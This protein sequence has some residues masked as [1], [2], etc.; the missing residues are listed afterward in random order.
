MKLLVTGDWHVGAMT[1]GR[2]RT[3]EVETA[4]EVLLKR[5]EEW[6]PDG[7]VV[8]GDVFDRFRYPGDAAA[9]LVA[10]AF[11]RLL[12]L[13]SSPQVV[14]VRGNHDWA[15]VRIWEL[16]EGDNRLRV[17]DGVEALTLGDFELLL[18]PYLRAHQI[19]R[20]ETLESLI[21]RTWEGRS[22]QGFPLCLGHL[23]LT[24]T[25]P[26]IREV[27]LDP[28]LLSELEMAA[29]ICGHIHRHGQISDMPLPAFYSGPLFPVDFS[30]EGQKIGA[31]LV[32]DGTIRSLPLPSRSLRTLQYPDVDKALEDLNGNLKE[33]DDQ[34]LV[35]VSLDT[36]HL[37]RAML[38]DRMRELPGGHRV[39]QVRILADP[40]EAVSPSV[41]PALDIRSLWDRYVSSEEPV[42]PRQEL[43]SDT[44]IALLNG[45]EPAA[46][47]ESLRH[48]VLGEV[49]G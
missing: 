33:M 31:L 8:L 34:T 7:V 49:R 46:V 4:L 25:I 14:F 28:A 43:L 24:G 16:L 2:D 30:E 22:G 41:D 47:W 26:G 42:G 29:V 12:D 9:E 10:G 44:G 19:P 21:R 18:V 13:P 1:W 45:E 35:R 36:A 32:E 38:L 20:E 48:R 40:Q 23:A 37:S 5:A 3:P 17:V 27:T 39:V 15:G 6:A 11:R